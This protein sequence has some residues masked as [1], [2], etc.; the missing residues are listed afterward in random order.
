MTARYA[1]IQA[2][3][4]QFSAEKMVD[5]LQVSRSGYYAW[6]KHP[7]SPRQRANEQLKADIAATYEASRNTYGSPRVTQALR[8]SG[9]PVGHNRV[10]RLMRE[11]ELQA[12]PKKRWKVTTQSKHRHLVAENSLAREFQAAAPDQKWVGDITYILTA[13]GWLYLAVVLDLYS[14]KVVGWSMSTE[15]R[16]D[17]VLDALNMAVTDRKPRPGLLFHSDRG[18][19]YASERFRA[20]LQQLGI[21]QSMSRKGNCWDNACVESFFGTMKQE[22]CGRL[23]KSR[24]EARICLFDYIAGFYN[25]R[26]LHSTLGY[27]SPNQFERRVA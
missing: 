4:E 6:R 22:G 10:A 17:L 9:Q 23:F 1:W 16:T 8:Q 13:E 11:M 19:Q 5:A 7:Q 15:M 27:L 14:R 18:V 24:Q 20:R 25:P 3:Q 26:R 12:R 2:H 21:Q